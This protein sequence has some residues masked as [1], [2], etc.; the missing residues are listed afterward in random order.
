M[1]PHSVFRATVHCTTQSMTCSVQ[2]DVASNAP[3]LKKTNPEQFST[4]GFLFVSA[5]S[6]RLEPLSAILAARPPPVVKQLTEQLISRFQ[7]N[8]NAVHNFHGSPFY[9]LG[10]VLPSGGSKAKLPVGSQPRRGAR[11]ADRRLRNKRCGSRFI[12]EQE[13]KVGLISPAAS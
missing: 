2:K 1:A 13:I 12:R 10:D 7:L 4:F 3:S 11:L 6:A 9:D 5:G 8:M